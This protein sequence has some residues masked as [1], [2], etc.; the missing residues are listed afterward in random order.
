MGS[1]CSAERSV[2]VAE[3]PTGRPPAPFEGLL[4]EDDSDAPLSRMS[5]RRLRRRRRQQL[6]DEARLAEIVALQQSLAAMEDF[7]QSLLGQ[8]H[9]YMEAMDPQQ[10]GNAGPPPASELTIQ[11]LEQVDAPNEACGICGECF[12]NEKAI[13]LPCGHTFHKQ[14]CIVPW[15]SRHCTCPVCRYELPTDD[16]AYEE[17]RIQRMS[18]R[19]VLSEDESKSVETADGVKEVIGEDGFPLTEQC[20][21]WDQEPFPF[22]VWAGD[23]Q[24]SPTQ[25]NDET[26]EA[27][28]IESTMT[29]D[30][31]ESDKGEAQD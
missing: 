10:G 1:S 23:R 14:N 3:V 13:R 11:S 9:H 12:G 27:R 29:E 2:A 8:A 7:F 17:G 4:D 21:E 15:L 24:P 20:R 5:N 6:R 31:E 25:L 30:S 16:A 28:K 19:K 22:E 18:M 26:A